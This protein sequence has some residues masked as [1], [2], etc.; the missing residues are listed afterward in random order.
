MTIPDPA[1][2]LD[3]DAIRAK[4]WAD[5][6]DFPGAEFDRA[7]V[8]YVAMRAHDERLHAV[9]AQASALIERLT[10]Q[11]NTR[12]Q[13]SR[14]FRMNP[15]SLSMAGPWASR[16][17]FYIRSLGDDLRAFRLTHLR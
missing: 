11:W 1:T 7:Q 14:R 6:S 4:G 16:A 10:G 12:P 5:R 9:R 2:P 17:S 15:C 13:P 8:F 3:L